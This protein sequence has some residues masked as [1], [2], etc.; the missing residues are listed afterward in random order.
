MTSHPE[1]S[2]ANSMGNDSS[3][4]LRIRGK[5]IASKLQRR[6]GLLARHRRE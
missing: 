3:S 2:D 5:S 6:N 1:S 4:R